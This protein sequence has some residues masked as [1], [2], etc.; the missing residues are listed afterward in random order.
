MAVKTFTDNTALPASDINTFLANAGLVYITAGTASAAAT[1]SIN[2]CFTATYE[3][4]FL[5]WN[6]LTSANDVAVNIRFR[7]SGTDASTGYRYVQLQSYVGL[8]SPSIS[9]SN[10]ATVIQVGNLSNQQTSFEVWIY[11]PQLAKYTLARGT[12]TNIQSGGTIDAYTWNGFLYNTTA[13]DGITVYPA[14]GTLTG[15][16]RVYGLRIA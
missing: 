13:Y 14:S 7:A 4:Y 1:L 8:A 2:S 16:L 11:N 6:G 9:G 5:T 15:T 12:S 3:N 10:T